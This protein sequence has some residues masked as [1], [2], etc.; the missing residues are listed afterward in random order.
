MSQIDG[1]K[2][3]NLNSTKSAAR[4]SHEAVESHTGDATDSGKSEEQ[5]VD[6]IAMESAKRAQNRIHNDEETTPGSTIF[7]K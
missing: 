1:T 7:S 4:P 2:N 5:H 3:L 6:R